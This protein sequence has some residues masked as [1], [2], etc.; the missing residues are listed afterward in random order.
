MKQ[1][2]FLFAAS[3]FL[4]AQAPDFST[5]SSAALSLQNTVRRSIVK[6]AEKMSSENYDFKPTAD[7]RSFG[8]IVAHTADAQYA[9][10]SAVLGEK[11]PAPG[12]EKKMKSKADLVTAVKA[13]FD[14]CD[15]AYA[16]VTEANA[17]EKVKFFGS[18]RTKL[19]IL[20]FNTMHLFE[21]YGNLVTYMRLKG[22]VP[23]SS[24][25]N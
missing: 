20:S 15:K 19:S 5:N 6:S 10:C 23:P 16:S 21:H 8:A 14:Y 3:S 9:F 4:I 24:E 7:V 25:H 11:N 1:I 2:F 17:G 22:V 13:A 18:D 12:V